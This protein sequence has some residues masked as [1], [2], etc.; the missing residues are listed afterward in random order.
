[1]NGP[2]QAE[3]LLRAQ[4]QWTSTGDEEEYHLQLGESLVLRPH[5]RAGVE[6]Q[7]PLW[8]IGTRG[9]LQAETIDGL[10]QGQIL[11]YETYDAEV[12]APDTFH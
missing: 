6:H 10:R 4:L 11:E 7:D 8:L 1:M 3:T 2:L 12:P 5:H 9:P